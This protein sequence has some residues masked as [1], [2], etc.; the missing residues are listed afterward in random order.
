MLSQDQRWRHILLMFS[1]ILNIFYSLE[2]KSAHSC[3]KK[4]GSDSSL[5]QWLLTY[6]YTLFTLKYH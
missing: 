2:Q 6:F 5:Y 4:N 3:Q 1:N